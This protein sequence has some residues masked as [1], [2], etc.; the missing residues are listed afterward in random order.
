MGRVVDNHDDGALVCEDVGTGGDKLKLTDD[1]I[2]DTFEVNVALLGVDHTHIRAGNGAIGATVNKAP[3]TGGFPTVVLL[4]RVFDGAGGTIR[5]VI[6][7]GRCHP[8]G[9]TRHPAG[10]GR[11]SLGLGRGSVG[12]KDGSP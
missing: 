8:V 9:L 11:V 2:S 1:V 3:G 12:D 7:C 5:G 4:H 6:A 10:M